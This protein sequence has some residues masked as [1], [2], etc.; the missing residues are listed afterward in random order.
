ML[1]LLIALCSHSQL[2]RLRGD[3]L[4][5]IEDGLR[6][7]LAASHAR[8]AWHRAGSLLAVCGEEA[9]PAADLALRVLGSLRAQRELLFGFSL[10]LED[11]PAAPDDGEARRLADAALTLVPEEHLWVSAA[12]A[13]RFDG[14]LD[15]RPHGGLFLVVGPVP[16]PSPAADGAGTG[17]P[18]PAAG[19]SGS[20]ARAAAPDSWSRQALV[21]RCLDLL[22][23]RLNDGA[24]RGV[25]FLHGPAGAGKTTL[26][27]ESAR[28]LGCVGPASP[29]RAYALF[30]RRTPLHPFLN[31]LDPGFLPEVPSLLVGPERG[32]W[33]DLGWILAGIARPG[34][35]AAAPD[36]VVTDFFLA[37]RLYARA[38]ARRAA[39]SLVPAIVACEDVESW[40]PEARKAAA[41]LVDDLLCEP[42]VIAVVTSAVEAL[43]PEFAGFPASPLPVQPLGRREIRSFGQRL[44]PGLELPE[45]VVRRIRRRSG[46]LP[47]A[48]KSIL[49]HLE[50]SGAIRAEGGREPPSPPPSGSPPREGF[51]WVQQRDGAETVPADPLSVSWTQIRSLADDSFTLLHALYLAAGLLDREGLLDFLA[52]EGVDRR[53]AGGSLAALLAAGLVAEEDCLVP[54]YPALRRRLEEQL[55]GEASRLSQRFADHLVG[56]WERG[57]FHR[58]VLLFS[59][60]ARAGR[61]ADA[62]RVLPGIVRRKI[63]E[64]DLGG[65]RAFSDPS[66]FEFVRPPDAAGRTALGVVCTAGRLRA[67]LMEERLE[68]AG[69]LVRELARL[70][71]EGPSHVLAA[72]AGLAAARYYL[73][74]GDSSSALDALKRGFA[75]A[76]EA[77]ASG[78]GSGPRGVAA[79]RGHDAGR[80]ASRR[81]G[82]VR[83][84]RGARGAGGRRPAG[85]AAGGIAA[86]LLPFPRG[87]ADPR[88]ASARREA[89]RSPRRWASA[90]RRS[91]SVSSPPGSGSCSA[92]TRGARSACSGA[93]ASRSSTG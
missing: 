9:G 17:G 63:D 84:P 8:V 4:P 35:V 6:G 54:R 42:S 31:S 5:V 14:V 28:R 23:R 89:W 24:S 26:L 3:S 1:H 47:V 15:T 88:P 71:R 39:R 75:A 18:G 50:R 22:S 12:A 69:G 44:F 59:F 21:E 49:L 58:E 77:G 43:P 78:R 2:E 34:A 60:L 91:S 61:T 33:E 37:Y 76:Q 52:G 70:G 64:R 53:E 65:A 45:A 62:L 56:L 83:G 79:A 68:E 41:E 66:R 67:A 36:R 7:M 57:A 55:G 25:L 51:A 90:T 27:A 13:G 85:H 29:L 93:C 87:P 48:V 10:V 73:A 19:P 74:A 38:W 46:G 11:L 40:H 16:A 86:R 32:A 20:P 81:G 30:R 92:T 80:R 82:R 72:E